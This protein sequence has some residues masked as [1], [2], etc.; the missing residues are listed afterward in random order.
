MDLAVSVIV[1]EIG[2]VVR[3]TQP[4]ASTVRSRYRF[5][6]LAVVCVLAVAL[7]GC[8]SPTSASDDGGSGVGG[9]TPAAASSYTEDDPAYQLASLDGDVDPTNDEIAPYDKRLRRMARLCDG[10]RSL[11]ADYAVNGQKLL[12]KD[13]V[14]V[15]LR[16]MLRSMDG[17]LTREIAKA[18]GGDCIQIF[19]RLVTLL[20]DNNGRLGPAYYHARRALRTP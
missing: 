9:D 8:D 7:V 2:Q 10:P 5:G 20:R 14:D 1:V 3:L 11:M 6:P 18:A 15:T 19:A 4:L 13:D 12:A 16:L 17:S